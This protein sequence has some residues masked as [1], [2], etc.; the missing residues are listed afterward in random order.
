MVINLLALVVFIFDIIAI[1]DC[2]KK[3]MDTSKKALW[4]LLIIF[5][6]LIGMILYY[7]LNKNTAA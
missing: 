7:L 4:I 3:P 1:V 2:V 6:P 5:F